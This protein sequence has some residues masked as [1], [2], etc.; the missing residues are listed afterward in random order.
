[1]SD[2]EV[3]MKKLLFALL[4]AAIVIAVP[5]SSQAQRNMPPGAFDQ[6]PPPPDSGRGQPVKGMTLDQYDLMQ[7]RVQ[8]FCD[9]FIAWAAPNQPR[10]ANQDQW[11]RSATKSFKIK[12]Y[13]YSV[14]EQLALIEHCEN[15]MP[16]IRRAN[17]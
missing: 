4:S 11:R 15:L 2:G 14:T 1:M 16:M 5:H 7:E 10:G 13:V 3:E 17:Q 8:A 12:S 6:P 9:Y